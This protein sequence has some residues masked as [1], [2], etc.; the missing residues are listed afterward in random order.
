MLQAFES[1]LDSVSSLDSSLLDLFAR[2]GRVRCIF[3]ELVPLGFPPAFECV[4][5][6]IGFARDGRSAEGAADAVADAVADT[7][8]EAEAEVE[9]R[10]AD[11]L[12]LLRDRRVAD[13]G[14]CGR[15]DCGVR[16]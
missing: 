11:T 1:E 15:L 2:V 6:L 10:D 7:V 16:C 12:K 3:C 5:W 4:L 8:A 13:C 9:G 14:C